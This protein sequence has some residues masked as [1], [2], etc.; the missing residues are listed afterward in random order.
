MPSVYTIRAPAER[1]DWRAIKDQVSLEAVAVALLGEAP[2]RRGSGGLWWACPLHD[3]AN[4]S[5]NVDPDRRRWKCWGCGEHGDA[6]ALAMRKNGSTFPEAVRFVAAV[7]GLGDSGGAFRAPTPKGTVKAPKPPPARSSGLPADQAL[8]L[9]R[10]AA[11][12]LWTTEGTEALAYL[13]DRGLTDEAIRS[14]SL[15]YVDSVAIP[16]RDGDRAIRASGVSI[17]WFDADRLALVKIRQSEGRKPKYAQAFQDRPRIF[18]SPQAVRPGRPLVVVEGEFD[19]LLLGQELGDRAAVVTLGSA[20]ARPAPDILGAML[21]ASPWYVATDAD[22]AGDNA[23][24]GWPARTRRVRPPEPFGDWTEAHQGGIDLRCWWLP[25]L[26]G[27]AALWEELTARRWGPAL[28]DHP[29]ADDDVAGV[30]PA[31]L[32][33]FNALI[34]RDDR[35]KY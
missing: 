3:D 21:T 33:E 13:H 25:R 6:A 22:K 30:D 10:E 8:A 19:A 18:P 1:I 24:T 4:P 26:G 32:A 35:G 15:G 31:W 29:E 11:E 5:F 7:C 17:P 27:D 9:V 14:A 16:T 34:G 20:S 2:G 23:A 12:R 28:S